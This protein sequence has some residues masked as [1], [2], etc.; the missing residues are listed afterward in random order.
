MRHLLSNDVGGDMRDNP[1]RLNNIES[2]GRIDDTI[3][4][5]PSGP[6]LI[7][8]GECPLVWVLAVQQERNRRTTESFDY[9]GLDRGFW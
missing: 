2:V 5:K 1:C 7:S 6:C 3:R 4:V 8:M 9:Q